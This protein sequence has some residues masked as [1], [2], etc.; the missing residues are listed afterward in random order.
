MTA[1][2]KVGEPYVTAYL[3]TDTKR[4]GMRY[5]PLFFLFVIILNVALYRSWRALLAFLMP[6]GACVALTL[7]FIGITGGVTSRSSR[8][9]VPMTILVTA[10]ATLVYL[11]SRFVE[12]PPGV[13]VDAHQ[14]FAL[15]NKF[16]ACT[17]SIF[18][19][20]VGFAALVVSDIRPIREMGVWVAVGLCIT[21]LVVFTLFP[22]LQK[23]LAHADLGG[24][25]DVG[26]VVRAADRLAAGVLVSLALGAGAERAGALGARRGR[27]LRHSRLRS[28]RCVL[29]DPVELRP[30]PQS[31]LYRDTIRLEKVVKGLAVTEVWLRKGDKAV[32]A[33]TDPEVIRGL[34][35]FKPA[36][37]AEPAIGAAVGPTVILR[38][39]R[40]VR[41]AARELPSDD[42]GLEAAVSGD[43][44]TGSPR[45]RCCS[46]SFRH[47]RLTRR[48]SPSSPQTGD[49]E[50]FEVLE[51]EAARRVRAG[52]AG[53][54]RARRRSSCRSSAWRRCRPRW[55]RAWCRRWSRASCS[56]S[57]SS[58]A[59]SCSCSATA[60][61]G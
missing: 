23:I 27:A 59:R 38:S 54:A 48:T 29:R 36:L 13:D 39:L 43:S 52:Q 15:T 2:R 40:Y 31:A 37:E 8:R 34:D 49:Y 3:D 26:P 6:L 7:G 4:A 50:S 16:L 51:G 22:A 35:G 57:A 10:T 53:D 44:R 46:A 45:S 14:I 47:R 11:H 9:C 17:A 32:G 58:S 18:A 5:F 1:I 19:T 20:A 25:E 21:W 61:R 42:A 24:A 41:A 30:R 56:P 60:P 33:V 12:R 28:R 55:R